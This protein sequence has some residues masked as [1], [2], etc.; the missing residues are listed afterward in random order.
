MAY[1]G[2][3]FS[4]LVLAFICFKVNGMVKNGLRADSAIKQ[5]INKLWKFKSFKPL[6]GAGMGGF[7]KIDMLDLTNEKFLTIYPD[8]NKKESQQAA[9]EIVNNAIVIKIQDK[10]SNMELEIKT[11]TTS[12]LTLILRVIYNSSTDSKRMGTDLL[13]LSFEAD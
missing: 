2:A 1:R 10:E 6:P 3:L 7:D 5:T 12:T 9:Y 11:L 13:E 8:R 4:F